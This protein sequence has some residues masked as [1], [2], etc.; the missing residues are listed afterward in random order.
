MIGSN[1]QSGVM[2]YHHDGGKVGISLRC[3]YLAT[4]YI[5]VK[6]EGASYFFDAPS[7]V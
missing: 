6:M 7:W 2:S 1:D 5:Y 3:H 4:I